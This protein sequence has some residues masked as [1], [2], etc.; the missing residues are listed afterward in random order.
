MLCFAKK[1]KKKKWC[2]I[3]ILPPP[4]ISSCVIW[5]NLLD[6][7]ESIYL[8]CTV[9]L[10]VSTLEESLGGVYIMAHEKCQAQNMARGGFP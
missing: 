3:R 10:I 6:I 9:E 8:I 5:G 4:L 1:K 7:A 2:R